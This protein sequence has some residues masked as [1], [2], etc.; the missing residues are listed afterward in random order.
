MNVRV[1]AH[2]SF[3]SALSIYVFVAVLHLKYYSDFIF[4]GFVF[5][6]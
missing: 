5:E 4:V 1:L 6:G 3:Y 2:I